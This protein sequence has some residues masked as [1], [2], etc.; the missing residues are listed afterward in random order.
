MKKNLART[1][2]AFGFGRLA[3]RGLATPLGVHWPRESGESSHQLSSIVVAHDL[4]A[5]E[6]DLDAWLRDFLDDTSTKV[7][8]LP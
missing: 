7:D 4:A 1:L 3:R 6:D 2:L 5:A 8:N